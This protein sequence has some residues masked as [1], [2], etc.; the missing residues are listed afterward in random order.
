MTTF[1]SMRLHAALVL[2]TLAGC[3]KTQAPPP[4][5]VP[6][7]VARAER[8]PVPFDLAAT[9]SVEPLQTV[10]V[11]PQVSGPLVRIAFSEGQ[12]VEKGQVLFQIDPR[13]FKA[14]LDQA[15]AALDRDRA[16]ATNAEQD[17]KRYASLSEKEYVTTQQYDQA[18][19]TDAAARATLAGSQAAVE[20][21]RLNLQYA[22]IR[23]PIAGR[24]GSLRVR[25]GNLVRTTDDAPLVT[26][27]QIRPILVRFAVPA[28]NL[29]VIQSRAQKDL[30]I[31]AE[32]TGGEAGS[33]GRLSFVDNAVDTA[34][35]T[36][37]LKGTFA[38]G[39]GALWP[40]EFVNVRLRLYTEE[41]A[42]VVPSSAVV[43]G[44]QGTY[45]FVI[46]PN[47]TAGT[48]KLKVER[49]AGDVSVVS[50]EVQP[51]DQV[52][53]DGQ[54]RLRVGS[55][56]QINSPGDSVRSGAGAS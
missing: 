42:L 25:Q 12:E 40:G 27:N 7:T 31:R 21:A 48:R 3:R 52:V 35:G 22:T 1:P 33:E 13:P 55:K 26:I 41:N 32:P 54:L 23:A 51:G 24:T 39:D 15:Q 17:A 10:A 29:G 20:Q 30:V 49:S 56:V 47:G 11:L 43:S 38:N 16:Q 2:V 34:T 53:T 46:Q 28:S 45:A 5:S 44:Q 19:T 37:L 9:G 14:A 36:I 8:R 6:V 4:A 18:R 50:G